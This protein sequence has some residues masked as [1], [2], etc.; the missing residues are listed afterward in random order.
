V[1][2]LIYD[3]GFH[4]MYVT[5]P[6]GIY[7]VSFAMPASQMGKLGISLIELAEVVIRFEFNLSTSV[8][9]SASGTY[10]NKDIGTLNRRRRQWFMTSGESGF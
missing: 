3:W 1:L 4:M 2:G 6:Q 9:I 8:Y 10:R 7:G 5:S